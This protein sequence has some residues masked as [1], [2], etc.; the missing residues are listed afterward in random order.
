MGDMETVLI[1]IGGF[2]AVAS[3]GQQSFELLVPY[4][5]QPLIEQQ[6]EDILLIVS[7]IDSAAQNVR[8][9]PQVPLKLRLR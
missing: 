7:S 5:A 8:R 3:L 4:V 2:L 6:A 9:T 1:R